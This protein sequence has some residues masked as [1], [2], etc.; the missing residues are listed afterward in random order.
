[1]ELKQDGPKEKRKEERNRGRKQ[2]VDLMCC[3]TE[4]ICC[5]WIQKEIRKITVTS[6]FLVLNP[7]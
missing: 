6:L 2:Y 5:V 4:E 7:P 1:M 3:K